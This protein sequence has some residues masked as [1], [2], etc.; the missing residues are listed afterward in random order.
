MGRRSS[1]AA[2]PFAKAAT[3]ACGSQKKNQRLMPF[4][5]SS[6][7][8]G[9][10]THT[11]STRFFSK[12]RLKSCLGGGEVVIAGS[13]RFTR[14][15]LRCRPRT[16]YPVTVPAENAREGPKG[17]YGEAATANPAR[18]WQRVG[19]DVRV[20]RAAGPLKRNHPSLFTPFL[21]PETADF[22]PVAQIL[23]PGELRCEWTVLVANEAVIRHGQ[24]MARAIH[25]RRVV[26]ARICF[27]KTENRA[28]YSATILEEDGNLWNQ[29]QRYIAI[30][31][32]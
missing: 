19:R 13:G 31:R 2:L 28:D 25:A 3:S 5:K 18:V 4:A 16:S 17:R 14:N 23:R 20:E 29:V 1:F 21:G 22:C 9:R 30:Y 32:R 7:R 6:V 10:M 11:G 12:T 26:H 27:R 24:T 15:L 8:L